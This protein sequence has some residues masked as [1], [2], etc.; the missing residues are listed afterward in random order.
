MAHSDQISLWTFYLFVCKNGDVLS[1]LVTEPGH[2]TKHSE[3]KKFVYFYKKSICT[4]HLRNV[5]IYL[6]YFLLWNSKIN[7]LIIES[8]KFD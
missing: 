2:K 7:K 5:N 8:N 6:C 3:S 1:Q 4:K